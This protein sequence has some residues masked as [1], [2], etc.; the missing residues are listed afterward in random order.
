ME[1]PSINIDYPAWLAGTIDWNRSYVS[2]EDKMA[3]AILLSRL[4]VSHSTGEPFGAAIFRAD[5]GRLV[6]VGMSQVVRQHNSILHAEV[7]AI[8]MAE[9]RLQA[10]NL[11]VGGQ[12][13][14]L[15]SSCEPCAMCLGATHWSRVTR[16][17]CGAMR[18]D[19]QQIGFDEG[20]V[21]P[22]S[23]RYLEERGVAIV[24]GVQREE[25]RVVIE[26]YAAEGGL[27]HNRQE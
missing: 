15:F 3:V 20:P 12:R 9:Q 10:F 8:M 23:Y 11:R 17:V 24:R 7:M 18:D 16:L 14:E 4:N 13:H 5:D 1:I 21:F 19:A 25:A 26:A 22:A 2:D 27:I 6:S